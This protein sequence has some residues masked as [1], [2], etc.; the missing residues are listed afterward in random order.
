LNTGDNEKVPINVTD[1]I[2]IKPLSK[3]VCYN[4]SFHSDIGQ[5]TSHLPVLK[6]S[7]KGG[8]RHLFL[9]YDDAA[10]GNLLLRFQRNSP[11]CQE[12]EINYPVTHHQSPENRILH[13][14]PVWDR[15]Y[16]NGCN[17]LEICMMMMTF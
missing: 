7:W 13:I 6:F 5:S 4:W 2:H 12:S 8:R 9:E 14:S 1:I 11:K 17:N 10:L 15:Q 16:A 3:I